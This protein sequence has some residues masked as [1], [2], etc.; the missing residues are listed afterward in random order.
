MR[1]VSRHYDRHLAAC[2]LKTTQYSLLTAVA[3]RG[4]LQQSDLARIL[5][6][7]ASTVT[8]NLRPL[9][10]AGM[11]AVSQGED[12]RS[13]QV[14]ITRAGLDLRTRA[15]RRWQQAQGTF[16]R[17]V[18]AER[19]AALHDLLDTCQRLLANDSDRPPAAR[20]EPLD[21]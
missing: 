1:L 16:D 13:N 6:L 20:G 21:H 2:G 11:L 7:D 5:S 15:R 8:R 17:T 3:S 9:V 19:V 10:D 4:P 14:R 12:G 18:G